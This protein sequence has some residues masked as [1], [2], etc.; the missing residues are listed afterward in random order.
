MNAMSSRETDHESGG[1]V[2]GIAIAIVT[3]NQ[4]DESQCRVKVRYPWH[5]QPS[6]SYWA[7]LAMPMAGND[8]GFVF[9]PEVDDEVIVAFERED[10]R[11]P[12]ILGA[13]YNGK[14]KPP[15]AN[16][17]GNNDK[18][19]MQSRKKHFLLFDD[20]S[21]GE[22]TLKH[23]KGRL[24]TF[25]DDGIVVKDENG[26]QIKIESTTGTMS[27]EAKGPLKIKAATITLEATGTMDLKSSGTLNVRG[28]LVNIN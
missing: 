24:V 18:R 9:I 13:V 6:D 10:L 4:D 1:Y 16:N 28:S 20:G 3:R 17:D 14:D 7:R 5:E 23:E 19:I 25:D 26:N 15:L 22:V 21:R 2:K 11:F 8:R 12:V 27:I